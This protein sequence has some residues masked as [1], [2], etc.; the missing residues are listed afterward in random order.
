MTR[1]EDIEDNSYSEAS[2]DPRDQVLRLE[3]LIEELE[4]R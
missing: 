2:D 4:P 3:V 1:H